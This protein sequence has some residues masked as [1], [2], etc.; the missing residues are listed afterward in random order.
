M[1][2]ASRLGSWP[3]RLTL[4]LVLV[5][6]IR[7]PFLWLPPSS[8][9][10]GFYQV[11][12]AWHF[13]GPNLYGHY[14]VDRPPG[15]IAVFAFASLL[16]HWW[17]VRVI[18]IGFAVAFVVLAAV[19]AQRAGGS[20][21]WAAVAAAG[22]A[23]T[24]AIQA[25]LATGELLAIPFVMGSVA[26]TLGAVRRRG[27]SAFAHAAL[28]GVAAALAMSIKQ[29]FA[30]GFAFAIFLVAASVLRREI[31]K[32]DAVTV[33]AGGFVGAGLVGAVMVAVGMSSPAGLPGLWFAVVEFRV[34]A[35]A[36]VA[37][38]STV[39]P[40][41]RADR[42]VQ[43]AVLTG[44]VPIAV[45]LLLRA[46][47]AR[48]R[49]Q[50][51]SWAIG[52][53]LVVETL[54]VLGGGSY[55]LHYLIQPAPMLALAVGRWAP[56]SRWLRS[57]G[58]LTVGSAL[59]FAAATG[60]VAATHEVDGADDTGAWVA[61]SARPGD[62]ATVLFGHA[63][64]QLATGL[65]SPYPYLWSLPMRTLDPHLDRLIGL[66]RGPHAPTW[67]VAYKG[68]DPWGIDANGDLGRSITQHYRLAGTICHHRVWLH[69]GVRRALAT[70]PHCG[71]AMSTIAFE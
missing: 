62:T 6:L 34:L 42:L 50:A 55:W 38:H 45:V 23:V 10:A 43:V 36:I 40:M 16:G 46:G 22:L 60:A 35:D 68:L 57:A 1:G 25:P 8:D 14:W 70:V 33:L 20:R 19:A 26:A 24:P 69:D 63:E 39:A 67:I 31:R 51:V 59:F 56:G 5:A 47:R 4:V 13:G 37:T 28:A 27:R 2:S 65:P 54:A 58:V 32:R 18:A 17:A 61:Q 52:L 44:M 15:L 11:A 48:M 49:G 71:H 9:E 64:V 30:G 41:L 66:I 53:T 7:V 29:S 3:R 21:T 12:R